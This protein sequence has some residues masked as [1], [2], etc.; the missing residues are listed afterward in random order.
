MKLAQ[1]ITL[2]FVTALSTAIGTVNCYQ[3]TQTDSTEQQLLDLTRKWDQAL[4]KRDIETLSHT[5]EAFRGRP[6]I[7]AQHAHDLFMELAASYTHPLSENVLSENIFGRAGLTD[8]HSDGVRAVDGDPEH[9]DLAERWFRVGAF[10]FGGVRDIVTDSRLR[11]GIG[12]DVTFYHVPQ[13]LKTLY[14]SNPTSFHVFLRVR[15]G[16]MEH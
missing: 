5:G 9:D 11:V 4:I 7:D 14:G 10:T 2:M 15:P 6:I 3:A 13:G 8:H 16:K 1:V 12:A